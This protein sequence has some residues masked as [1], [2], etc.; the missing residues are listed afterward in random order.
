MTDSFGIDGESIDELVDAAYVRANVVLPQR[1]FFQG[2]IVLALSGL[3][4]VSQ[5]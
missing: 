4:S 5:N 1:S 3:D 2:E